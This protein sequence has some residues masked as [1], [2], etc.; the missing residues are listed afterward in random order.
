[1]LLQAA[2]HRR[3]MAIADAY[4]RSPRRGGSR[5]GR[6]GS[7]RLDVYSIQVMSPNCRIQDGNVFGP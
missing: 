3:A 4:R 1:V 2:R 5:C 6:R 7:Q